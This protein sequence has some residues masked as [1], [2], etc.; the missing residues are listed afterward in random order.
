M[1]DIVAYKKH[2]QEAEKVLRLYDYDFHKQLKIKDCSITLWRETWEHSENKETKER[3]SSNNCQLRFCP[4]C[5]W[6]KALKS[7][8][9][10]FTNLSKIENSNYLF[11]TLTLKNCEIL[12]LKKTLKHMSESFHRLKK[13][14]QWQN[15]IKG[16]IRALEITVADD[17]LMHPHFHILLQ[18]NPTYGNHK[19]YYIT[20]SDFTDLWQ[21]SLK[22][23]YKPIVDVRKIKPKNETKDSLI[24]AVAETIKYTLKSSDLLKMNK[25]TFPILD[26]SMKGVKTINCG[27]SLLHVQK[28]SKDDEMKMDDWV[29][30]ARELFRW[31]RGD[32][33]LV[34]TVV[35]NNLSDLFDY[36]NHDYAIHPSFDTE[37]FDDLSFEMGF[38]L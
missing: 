19:G 38:V 22:V 29:L 32:Y 3:F 30:L 20:Q 34:P 18:V 1:S 24:S 6:R 16:Y 25:Y 13:T 8:A 27:G 5:S 7:S 10:I 14:V 23:D 15:S 11:L 26:E 21:K 9:I 12:D 33:V 35:E 2:K 31:E 4:V 17:G 36:V 37:S 28:I